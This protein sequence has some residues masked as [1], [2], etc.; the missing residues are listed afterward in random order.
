MSLAR[1]ISVV[2]FFWCREH[3][4]V[5]LLGKIFPRSVM[6]SFRIWGDL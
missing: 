4:P 1:L 3:V 2:S 5:I 6:K